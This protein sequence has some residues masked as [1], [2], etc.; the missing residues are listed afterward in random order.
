MRIIGNILSPPVMYA[1]LAA[2]MKGLDIFVESPD[3]GSRSAEHLQINP[4]GKV[5]VLLYT[6]F[7]L[8]ESATI[9]EF[10]EE[11][12]DGP[13]ILPGNSEERARARLLARVAETYLGPAL[14]PLLRARVEPDAVGPALTGVREALGWL[15][16]LMPLH[17]DWLAGDDHSVA[18]CAAMPLFFYLEALD[19]RYGTAEMLASHP[20]LFACW[21]HAK[22]SEHGLRMLQEM[23]SELEAWSAAA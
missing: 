20:G 7:A 1:V 8:P 18:D 22:E 21:E 23:T 13:S 2:R 16:A 14:S 4:I 15:E 10:L 17:G 12:L 11:E 3:G 6:D 9:A 5:P 19:E